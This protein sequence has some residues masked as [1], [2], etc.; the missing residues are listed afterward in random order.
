MILIRSIAV[1]A[2]LFIIPSINGQYL[3]QPRS[4]EPDVTQ[5]DFVYH[6]HEEMTNFLR[7]GITKHNKKLEHQM[8]EHFFYNLIIYFYF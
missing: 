2:I 6:N 1:I 5:L 4:Y 7:Y 3:E 8:N